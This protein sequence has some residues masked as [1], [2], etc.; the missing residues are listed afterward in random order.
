MKRNE[1]SASAVKLQLWFME[2]RK[3]V[4]LLSKGKTFDEIGQM[5]KEENVFDASTP[6]RA[7]MIFKTLSSRIQSLNPSFYPLFMDSDVSTQKIYALTAAL[8][9]D[10]LFF[11]FMYEV[12]RE[13]LII[14]SNDL[15]DRD[16]RV[17]FKNK[18]EQ[19][20]KA[21]KWTDETLTRLGRSYKTHLYEAG[22]LDAPTKKATDRKLLPPILDVELK[23]WL[24]DYGYEYIAKAYEGVR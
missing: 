13:K 18:Q 10:T 24:E 4:A 9:Y 14:G 7:E 5:S 3:M 21:A 2:F 1:Y 12:I 16:I 11:D 8:S 19:D 15:S 23:H 17:F 20:D 6:A 22:L